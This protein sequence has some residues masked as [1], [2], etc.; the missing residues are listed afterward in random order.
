MAHGSDR[1]FF[2]KHWKKYKAE[3]RAK[4]ELKGTEAHRSLTDPAGP[5]DM[6]DQSRRVKYDLPFRAFVDQLSEAFAQFNESAEVAKRVVQKQVAGEA[7][8]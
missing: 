3:M 4:C 8:P 5:Y 7:Q 2:R 6:K 1:Q